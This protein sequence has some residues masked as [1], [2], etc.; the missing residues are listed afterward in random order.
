M[1]AVTLNSPLN[2]HTSMRYKGLG[3]EFF[4]PTKKTYSEVLSSIYEEH[5]DV[6]FKF[7]SEPFLAFYWDKGSVNHFNESSNWSGICHFRAFSL[8]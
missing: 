8:P 2:S 3:L 4:E 6:H 5:V 1:T 7:H